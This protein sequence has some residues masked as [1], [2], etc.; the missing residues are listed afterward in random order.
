M[1]LLTEDLIMSM[2]H[3]AF[4]FDN[5]RFDSEL[6]NLL[7]NAGLSNNID[8]IKNFIEQNKEEIKNPYYGGIIDENWEDTMSV[9][10]VQEYADFA[11][12]AY[13]EPDE[14]MGLAYAWDAVISIL[15]SIKYKKAEYAVLGKPIKKKEFCVDPGCCGLGIVKASDVEKIFEQL[16][17]LQDEFNEMAEEFESDDDIECDDIISAFED[18]LALYESAMDEGCGLLLTF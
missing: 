12:T 5:E 6:R 10:D 15:K 18:L 17:E 13:Y 1:F 3:R 8:K 9:K 11:M 4:V 2:E 7:L 16:S 14:D